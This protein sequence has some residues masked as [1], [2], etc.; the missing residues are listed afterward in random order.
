[1]D[2]FNCNSWCGRLLRV[3]A[4][5]GGEEERKP[6]NRIV[7]AVYYENLHLDKTTGKRSSKD[8]MFIS[9]C[10]A[11]CTETGDIFITM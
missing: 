6:D 11:I 1:M 2:V 3:A 7:V 4:Q 8:I 10:N 5:N 9:Y